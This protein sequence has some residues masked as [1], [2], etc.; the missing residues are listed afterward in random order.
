MQIRK[1]LNEQI[2]TRR[3]AIGKNE[4]QPSS[5]EIEDGFYYGPRHRTVLQSGNAFSDR[6]ILPYLGRGHPHTSVLKKVVR[7]T[8]IQHKWYWLSKTSLGDVA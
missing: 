4:R 1:G 3:T 6:N 5:G 7:R 2:S 8:T